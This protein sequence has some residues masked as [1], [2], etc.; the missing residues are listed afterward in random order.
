MRSPPKVVM[1]CA[2]ASPAPPEQGGQLG[3][4]AKALL[5]RDLIHV[6]GVQH[7]DPYRLGERGAREQQGQ[8]GTRDHGAPTLWDWP[9][10]DA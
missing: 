5:R 6:V 1:P 2:A 4:A 9:G 7:R 10:H 8:G 3:E